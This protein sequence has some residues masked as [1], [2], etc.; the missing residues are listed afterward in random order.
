MRVIQRAID[1]LALF[2]FMRAKGRQLKEDELADEASA[3]GFLFD[4]DYTIAMD[5]YLV[6]VDCPKCNK[7]WTDKLSS[8]V[9]QNSTC[10]NCKYTINGKY[11]SYRITESQTIK[12]ITLED[13]IA[14]WGVEDVDG[15]RRGINCRINELVKT[16]LNKSNKS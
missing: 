1:D 16:K 2:R 9:G 8:I 15:F 13:L 3:K 11:T 5:D 7:S 12:E 6:D 14:L 10:P 4:K